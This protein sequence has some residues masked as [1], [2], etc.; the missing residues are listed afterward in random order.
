MPAACVSPYVLSDE[1]S[2]SDFLFMIF[3]IISLNVGMYADSF[4]YINHDT[5][6]VLQKLN[7]L[8]N[9]IQEI[10]IME[11]IIFLREMNPA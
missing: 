11:K 8:S 1:L 2:F 5:M 3:P 9:I 7:A 4:R 6:S 10:F